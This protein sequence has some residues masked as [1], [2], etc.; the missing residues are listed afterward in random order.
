MRAGD[1]TGSAARMT[2]ARRRTNITMRARWGGLC[3]LAGLLAS[4][5][6]AGCAARMEDDESLTIFAAASLADGFP[7]VGEAHRQANP[8][9]EI[10]FNF[11]ASAQLAP[12]PP[13]GPSAPL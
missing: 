5:W 12:P 9:A 7:A 3:G 6:V 4:A 8:A 13:A 1:P 2:A 11:A 10:V